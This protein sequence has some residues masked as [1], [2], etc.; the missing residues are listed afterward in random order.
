MASD[1][2][3]AVSKSVTS[4]KCVITGGVKARAWVGQAADFTGAKTYNALTKALSSFVLAEGAAFIKATGR[5]LKGSGTSAITQPVDGGVSNEQTV[6]LEFIYND[7]LEANAIM[8][9]LR[10]DG[11]TVFLETNAKTIRQYFAEFGTTNKAAEDSTG[12][13]QGD[14]SG[15]IKVTLKGTESDLPLF[16]EAVN[17]GAAT[18][19]QAS[20]DYL[21]ALVTG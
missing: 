8:E 5:A 6:I 17:P 11:L 13:A 9:L 7:Q 14:A 4:R 1:I 10:A 12:T 15:V 2:C 3:N 20:I 18:Q 21:D 16:F 19:L